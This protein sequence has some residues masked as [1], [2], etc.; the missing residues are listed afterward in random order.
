MQCF[1]SW[2]QLS[3]GTKINTKSLPKS[4]QQ[5]L[6]KVLSVLQTLEKHNKYG[7]FYHS[8]SSLKAFR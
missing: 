8:E 3:Y 4:Y 5:F 2:D 7:T 6:A 1:D